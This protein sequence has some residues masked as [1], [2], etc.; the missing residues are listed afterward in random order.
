MSP[1]KALIVNCDYRTDRHTETDRQ[2]LV[3]G[4]PISHS[5]M[6]RRH[7]NCPSSFFKDLETVGN[8]RLKTL[9][10]IMSVVNSLKV[11]LLV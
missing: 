2:T 7:K 3:I 6:H 9:M 4:I 11:L 8:A 5:A 10:Y 1:V